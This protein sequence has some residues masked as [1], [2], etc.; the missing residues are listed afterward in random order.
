MTAQSRFARCCVHCGVPIAPDAFYC[1]EHGGWA[2]QADAILSRIRAA[3]SEDELATIGAELERSAVLPTEVPGQAQPAQ[4]R[5]G[6]AQ[7]ERHDRA[8]S[9]STADRRIGI[10]G[11]TT[12]CV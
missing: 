3:S 1:A 10:T 11:N 8:I 5:Y 6:N 9:P 7:E 12:E 4:D 2:S